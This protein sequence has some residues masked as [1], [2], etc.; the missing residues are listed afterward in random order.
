M[1]THTPLHLAK[2]YQGW[3]G[4]QQHLVKALAPLSAE[5]LS[6]QIAPHLRSAY[7]IAAH[8]IGARARWSYYVLKIGGDAMFEI[9]AWDRS[10]QPVR[11]AAELVQGLE[12]T[13][14]VLQQALAEWTPEDLDEMLE[15]VD[16]DGTV[17]RMSRQWV[18]WHLIEH[19]IHHGGELSFVLGANKIPAIDL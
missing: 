11:S 5:Q 4:Y 18:I 8:I 13:W 19:D 14:D 17:E 16:D 12:R 7:T 6:S 3:D 15:D 10:G 9:G 2:F 1:N